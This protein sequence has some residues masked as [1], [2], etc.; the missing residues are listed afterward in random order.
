MPL[1]IGSGTKLDK[2][3]GTDSLQETN[4][5]TIYEVGNNKNSDSPFVDFLKDYSPFALIGIMGIVLKK[6][7]FN[8]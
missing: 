7:V 1:Q 5:S 4:S 2:E 6:R 3:I 8:P